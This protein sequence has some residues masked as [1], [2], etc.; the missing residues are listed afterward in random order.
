[1]SVYAQQDGA[2]REKKC[3]LVVDFDE[4]LTEKDTITP[5]I[6]NSIA[7]L[8]SVIDDEERKQQMKKEKE[9]CLN[10]LVETYVVQREAVLQDIFVM[11]EKQKDMGVRVFVS[12]FIGWN[13]SIATVGQYVYL[14]T[15][16]GQPAYGYFH[17]L[18]AL[19]HAPSFDCV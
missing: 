12:S 2:E 6:Y 10:E 13:F 19:P 16:A 4:T 15:T 11:W 9:R 1:M 17:Y 3:L 7:S 8:V 5:L 18:M 14:H